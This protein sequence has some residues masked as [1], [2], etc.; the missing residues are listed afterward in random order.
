M[1]SKVAH[2]LLQV[3]LDIMDEQRQQAHAMALD[4]VEAGESTIAVPG[5]YYLQLAI[6]EVAAFAKQHVLSQL[7]Q[8]SSTDTL[9]QAPLVRYCS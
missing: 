4:A 1:A 8:E 2:V 9:L 3:R 6:S 7:M 5:Q